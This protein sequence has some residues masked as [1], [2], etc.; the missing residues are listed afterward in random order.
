[1]SSL[2]A[3]LAVTLL[4]LSGCGVAPRSS[5]QVTEA[6]NFDNDPLRLGDGYE[7]QLAKLS[8][9]ASL[10]WAPWSDSYWP[11]VSGGIAF[12]W[13]SPDLDG[14][15]YKSPD[16]AAVAKMSLAD[17]SKLSPAE[18]YSVFVGDYKYGL[19]AS[20]RVRTNP[21][22]PGWEGICHGWAPASLFYEEPKP[23]LVTNAAGLKIPFGS[24]DIKAL[25]DYY[26]GVYS[27]APSKMLGSRC[28]VD[29]SAHPDLTNLPECRDVNAGSFHVV[30]TNFIG[31]R[32]QGFIADITR[33]AEVWNQPVYGYE[34]RITGKHGPSPGA[35]PGTVSEVEVETTMSYAAE[36]MANWNAVVGTDQS[37]V[38]IVIYNYR[39]ELNQKGEII[40]GEWEGW[41]RPDFLWTQEKL[42]FLGD[43][44]KLNDIYRASIAHGP[45]LRD[46]TAPTPAPPTGP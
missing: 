16:A 41:A 12:R 36:I 13:H 42:P 25:L 10:K 30:L 22:D 7:R 11:N 35:G 24:G 45:V 6:W 2:R 5:S 18:K 31:K 38:P 46:P 44:L 21:N 15:K 1:M 20:E 39:L 9:K 40:G 14:F 34:S 26:V 3:V 23:V 29:L 8:T 28:N 32:H 27:I 43:F 37:V 19:V 4:T 17:L 33:D